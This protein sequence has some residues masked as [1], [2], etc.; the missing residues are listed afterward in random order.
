VWR[1]LFDSG[2]A[3]PV[4]VATDDAFDDEVV[5]GGGGADADAEVYLPLR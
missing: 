2:V 4:E 1:E 3:P 5:G